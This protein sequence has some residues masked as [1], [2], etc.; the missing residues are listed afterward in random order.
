MSP[1][2]PS[3]RRDGGPPAT[4]VVGGRL[5]RD[6]RRPSRRRSSRHRPDAGRAG[7]RPA[8][9]LAVV[10]GARSRSCFAALRVLGAAPLSPV[11]NDR[12]L[13]S[14]TRSAFVL[15]PLS[16]LFWSRSR[17]APSTRSSPSR[18]GPRSPLSDVLDGWCAAP[19]ARSTAAWLLGCSDLRQLFVVGAGRANRSSFGRPLPCRLSVTRELFAVSHGPRLTAQHDAAPI[20]C[21]TTPSSARKAHD[22]SF[23]AVSDSRSTR[24]GLRWPAG[25]AL[26]VLALGDYVAARDPHRRDIPAQGN[27]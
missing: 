22:R 21:A 15:L 1:A 14:P 18:A 19:T 17:E 11:T 9:F 26:G 5:A 2:S 10:R 27:E 23:A 7:S 3:R 12:L 16:G 25:F 13:T 24:S 20:G 8:P 6:V 4:L